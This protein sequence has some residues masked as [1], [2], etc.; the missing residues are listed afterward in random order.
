[1]AGRR[2]VASSVDSGERRGGREG[3]PVVGRSRHAVADAWHRDAHHR[4]KGGNRAVNVTSMSDG[5]GGCAAVAHA[6]TG[7]RTLVVGMLVCVVGRRGGPHPCL[8]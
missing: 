8:T 1:M 3:Q 5:D 6:R 4:D 2:R 7:V